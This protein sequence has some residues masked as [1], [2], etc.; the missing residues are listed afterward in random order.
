MYFLF[1]YEPKPTRLLLLNLTD[2]MLNFQAMEYQSIPQLNAQILPGT[3]VRLLHVYDLISDC[4]SN[5]NIAAYET[6]V[7]TNTNCRK[8]MYSIEPCPFFQLQLQG[9]INCRLGLLLLTPNHVRILGGKVEAL[10]EMN[11]QKKV[12]ARML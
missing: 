10:M 6:E 1:Q 5:V 9:T 3:K 11:Q 2:G 12:L 4:S 8:N 7:T